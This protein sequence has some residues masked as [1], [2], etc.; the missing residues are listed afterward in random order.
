MSIGS[1]KK[2]CLMVVSASGY[3]NLGDEA[4]LSSNL[5][6]FNSFLNQ[7]TRLIVLS[8]APEVTSK[9]HKVTSSPD[10]CNICF[11]KRSKYKNK[12]FR[13]LSIFSLFLIL[14]YNCNQ[15][16]KGN[17]TRF[18]TS[19]EEDFLKTIARSK[20]LFLVGGG[21][22]NDIWWLDGL[23]MKGYTVLLAKNLNVPV[24]LGA[25]TIGPVDK[26]W[27]RPAV[28][29]FFNN[30]ELITLREYYSLN[31]LNDI[32][33]DRTQM[34]VVLDDAFN[35][36]IASEEE[37]NRLL[38]KEGIDLKMLSKRGIKI[39]ALNTRAWWKMDEKNDKLKRY[40]SLT[41]DYLINNEN[42]FIIFVPTAYSAD[43]TWDD[44]KTANELSST[45][46][47]DRYHVLKQQ[48]DWRQVK[49]ILNSVDFS[50]GS[51]YHFNVFSLS[52]KKPTLGIY[53]DEYSK[54]RIQGLYDLI[55]LPDCAVNVSVVDEEAYMEQLKRFLK[56]GPELS[57]YLTHLSLK[58]DC[59]P[60]YAARAVC[61]YVEAKY[62]K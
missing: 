62:D 22:I 26:K 38:S 49:G 25:Q 47:T 52:S 43:P 10:L 48:Y 39:I 36:E 3:G 44:I 18:L 7:S 40:I 23:L 5:K 37:V 33:I 56:S 8:F 2:D 11:T 13:V 59:Q 17:R 14:F 55:K 28:K 35:L 61:N 19:M 29:A 27:L 41:L 50:I 42:Y 4:I 57:D 30:L 51:S 15:I 20:A 45:N 32:G 58:E 46:E 24:F 54:M 16:K 9:L 60:C 12:I 34:K 31:L 21:N 53:S 1:I 6:I